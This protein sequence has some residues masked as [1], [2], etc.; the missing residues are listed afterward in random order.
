MKR[1]RIVLAAIPAV[2]ALCNSLL[3]LSTT[4]HEAEMVVT[5]WLKADPQPLDMA[6]GERVTR[7][8]TFTNDDAEP[9]YHIVYLHPSGYVIVAADDRVEPIIGFVDDTAYDPA[10]GSPLGALVTNDLNGR[11]GSV[12]RPFAP[13]ATSPQAAETKARQRWRDLIS[14]TKASDEVTLMGLPAISEGNPSDLRVA[15]LLRS[16]WG[17]R[18]CDGPN[19]QPQ[20][21]YNYYTPQF[22]GHILFV[23][24]DENNHPSGCVATTMAQLMHYHWHPTE[25]VEP[26]LFTIIVE[27]SETERRLLGGDGPDGAYNWT[28][29]VDEPGPGTTDKQRRAIGALCHDAG[30]SVGTEY[31][32]DGSGAYL[33]DAATALVNAFQYD[34]AVWAENAGNVTWSHD[35]VEMM[36]PNL[37]A[38]LPVLLGFRDSEHPWRGHSA[39]CDG[40]GYNMLTPYYHL[41]MGWD[42]LENCWYNLPDVNCP[43]AA[44]YDVIT[45]CIYNIFPQAAG[46]IIS[47]R[48]VD[49][50]G[51]PFRN[52]TV[53][54]RSESGTD[55]H[56]AVTNTR[57]IYAL[58]G[59]DSNT[60]YFM[61]ASKSGYDFELNAGYDSELNA[62][63]MGASVGGKSSAG[64]KWA[65]NFV[66]YRNAGG[67]SQVVY[68]D[69][70][71]TG[72]D[73][74]RD[75]H[76]GCSVSI[77]GDYA[78]VGAYGND[79]SRGA[80]YI[81]KREGTDWIQQAKIRAP[82]TQREREGYFGYSVSISGDYAIVG[83]GS[84]DG[85][86]RDERIGTFAAN[87]FKRDGTNWVC[88]TELGY[89]STDGFGGSVAIDGDYAIV[90]APS[91][92]FETS[93]AKRGYDWGGAHIFNRSGT[94]W[95]WQTR[96]LPWDASGRDYFGASVAIHGD[97]AIAAVEPH[98]TEALGYP[99][100]IFKR[101]D[102]SWT[103]QTLLSSWHHAFVGSLSINNEHA[104]IGASEDIDNGVSTGAAY[105]FERG[106][107]SWTGQTKL[108]ALDGSLG[109]DF[110]HSV[111][112]G[113][114]YIAVGAPK[115]D[116]D[117]KGIES[118]STHIFKREQASWPLQVKL[119]AR[120]GAY[121]DHFG[122]SVCIDGDCVIIG[123]PGDDD[124]GKGSGSA[125]IFKR[126][127]STWSP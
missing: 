124:N 32:A 20:A 8:E 63:V 13:L 10:P 110:G 19:A 48:I 58:T 88:Q 42:G 7:V 26:L 115:D 113:G 111:S 52:I 73:T 34:K 109:D 101:V 114:D 25:P 98:R 37:D 56:T 55:V 116:D 81:F 44:G 49:S 94:D 103:E 112:I 40:Y 18:C 31:T 87:I 83:S 75:D 66:G 24:G 28:D 16:Q 71:L 86:Y 29:M 67:D 93:I 11:I 22:S 4:A 95:T 41:N 3:A 107:I 74:E 64:N 57:G 96:L 92:D 125:Y 89:S 59:L 43:T 118:G 106:G 82:F 121:D 61:T 102:T 9:A 1:N 80:A 5:G 72:A 123:A 51:Q 70:K 117:Y 23:E 122:S 50:E 77:D 2:L 91:E 12:N 65:V 76:F 15:P 30:I 35:L 53:T 126:I 104:V 36:N 39:V 45:R 14:L 21:C 46:E 119:T 62:V 99:V 47:G 84:L 38:N 60:A 127:G 33:Y 79:N 90:G 27:G 120:D 97:Y 100:H 105:V 69:V 108:T 54:A 68:G 6:L 85:G 17:Q 78:I